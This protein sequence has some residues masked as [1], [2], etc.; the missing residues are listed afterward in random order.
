MKH[1]ALTSKYVGLLNDKQELKMKFMK[2][3]IFLQW[4]LISMNGS[5]Q[6]KRAGQVIKKM[7]HQKRLPNARALPEV[8]GARKD[9]S[10]HSLTDNL[11][12]EMLRWL[13]QLVLG[14][15]NAPFEVSISPARAHKLS[16]FPKNH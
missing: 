10:K 3:N 16:V 14:T 7:I 4:K 12:V 11:P 2:Q 5:A 13:P 6:R 1:E 15:E 8:T 9:A